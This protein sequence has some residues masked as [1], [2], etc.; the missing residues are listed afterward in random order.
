ML[1]LLM[2]PVKPSNDNSSVD[3]DDMTCITQEEYT[4]L[5]IIIY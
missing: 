3:H 5:V 1:K 2:K 4:E